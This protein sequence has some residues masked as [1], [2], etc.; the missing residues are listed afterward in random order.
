M[1]LLAILCTETK[2]SLNIVPIIRN[3]GKTLVVVPEFVLP[4]VYIVIRSKSLSLKPFGLSSPKVLV[5]LILKGMII[6]CWHQSLHFMK[7]SANDVCLQYL[8]T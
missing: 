6:K 2:K 1:Y 8:V 4:T 7:H 3:Y 5:E